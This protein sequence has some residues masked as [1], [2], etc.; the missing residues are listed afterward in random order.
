[1]YRLS[2]VMTPVSLRHASESR[3]I[4]TLLARLPD[5]VKEKILSFP[6]HRMGVHRVALVLK[7]GSLIEDV[8]VAWGDEVVRVGGVDRCHFEVANVVDVEDRS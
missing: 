3:E 5:H 1:M 8:L 2:T 6:E 7:D 4:V